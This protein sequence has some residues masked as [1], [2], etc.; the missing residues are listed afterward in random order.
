MFFGLTFCLLDTQGQELEPQGSRWPCS[1]GF[2]GCGQ[3]HNSLELSFLLAYLPEWSCTQ[4]ALLSWVLESES[5]FS[6]PLGIA[7]V[8]SLCSAPA[9]TASLVIALVG[10]FC[11]D[12]TPE[13]SSP[14]EP[15]DSTGHPLKSKGRQQCCTACVFFTFLEMALNICS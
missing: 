4:L 3:C 2:D 5:T 11:G 12:P 9:S 7:L 10:A 8:R 13:C 14:P 15:Q 1:H 6:A